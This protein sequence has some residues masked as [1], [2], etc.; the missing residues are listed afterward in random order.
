MGRHTPREHRSASFRARRVSWGRLCLGSRRRVWWGGAL[1]PRGMGHDESSP[2]WKRFFPG[3]SV[4]VARQA[5]RQAALLVAIFLRPVMRRLPYPA[6]VSPSG[7]GILGALAEP[8]VSPACIPSLPTRPAPTCHRLRLG[9]MLG[10]H[11]SGHRCDAR[12][13]PVF[14][15]RLAGRADPRANQ[16]AAPL[17]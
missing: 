2:R 7:G 4:G 9:P 16:R 15:N 11:L 1:L 6:A 13:A 12:V 5:G 14:L 17:V 10:E 3:R 8:S